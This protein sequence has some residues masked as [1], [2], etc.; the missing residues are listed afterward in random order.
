[1]KLLTH[2]LQSLTHASIDNH[3]ALGQPNHS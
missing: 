1:M 3:W 2:S